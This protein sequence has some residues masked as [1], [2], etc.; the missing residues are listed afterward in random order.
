MTERRQQLEVVLTRLR[1]TIE[2]RVQLLSSTRPPEQDRSTKRKWG[3]GWL[4]NLLRF[5]WQA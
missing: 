3:I 1:K 2:G 5:W 4:W